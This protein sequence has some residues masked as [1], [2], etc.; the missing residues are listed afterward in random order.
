M[1]LKSIILVLFFVLGHFC[2]FGQED[3]K[4]TNKKHQ[5]GITLSILTSSWFYDDKYGNNFNFWKSFESWNFTSEFIYQY[6][7]IGNYY[8][9]ADLSYIEKYSIS[10]GGVPYKFKFITFAPLIGRKFKHFI[11]GD[12]MI[13]FGTYMGYLLQAKKG[14]YTFNDNELKKWEFGVELLYSLDKKRKYIPINFSTIKI[15]LGLTEILYF[16]TITFNVSLIGFL[17]K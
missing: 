14:K 1:K 2:V 11:G 5:F 16:K 7:F 13:S 6:N 17:I 4:T 15:Q 8:G 3:K 9:T 12:F 10:L